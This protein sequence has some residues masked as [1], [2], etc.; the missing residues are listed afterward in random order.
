MSKS[1]GNVVETNK[2]LETSSSD[3]S[4]FYMMRKCPPT[5]FMNFDL[6]E[7]NR[8]PYQVLSTLYHLTRFFQQ[9]AEFDKFDSQEYTIEWAKK[10]DLLDTPDLWVLSKLQSTIYEYTCKLESCDFNLAMATL[11]DFVIETLSRLYVPMIRK[12]LWSDE[13]E[14]QRRRQAVYA[15]LHHLL[16][17][18]TL[19]FNPSTPFLSEAL[20]QKVYKKFDPSLPESINLA[21]WPTPNDELRDKK[22]E[23]EF[24]VLFKTVSLVYAA[25]QSAKVKRRWPLSEVKIVAPQKVLDA[26]QNE[27]SLFLEMVNV[28]TAKYS[29]KPIESPQCEEDWVSVTEDDTQILLS[30]KRD[31]TLMG[32]GIMRDL[33]RRVQALRK[34]LGYMPTDTIDAVHITGLEM[35]SI[36]LLNPYLK[37]MTALVRT[38]K[39][40]IHETPTELETKWHESELDGKKISINIH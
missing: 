29:A 18:I 16:K 33:A 30:K 19:L 25:R 35:E 12:E 10:M 32:E 6:Q 20:F 11:E 1:L 31:E 4:R 28:K 15:T 40:Y 24:D 37:D 14:T 26:L 9:N 38:K 22:L 7:L 8:R 13:I 5:D 39:V 36:N 23:Q 27:E 34:E 2:L 3:M 17:T 21:Q